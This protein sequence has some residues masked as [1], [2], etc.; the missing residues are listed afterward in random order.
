[1]AFWTKW[2]GKKKHHEF[3]LPPE[4]PKAV[5]RYFEAEIH[6]A[7]HRLAQAEER[8]PEID[9]RARTMERIHSDNALGPRFWK[10]VGGK[11]T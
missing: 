7:E 5:G 6:I 10:A 2:F 3:R 9:E 11:G 8:Q 4:P 1:V